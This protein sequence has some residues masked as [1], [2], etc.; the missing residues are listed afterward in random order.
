MDLAGD[1]TTDVR[2]Y[3]VLA[4]ELAQPDADRDAILA[5]HGLDE[6]AWDALDDAWQS[7]LSDAVEAMGEADD[8]PPLVQ[9]HAEAFAKAQAE[10]VSVGAPLAFER[11]IEIT[12]D[13]QRGKDVEHAMKRNGTTLHDYLRAQQ[14]WLKQM[15]D[16][17]ALQQRFHKAMDRRR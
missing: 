7:R 13:I 5:R 8:V 2:A 10:R 1:L 14:H 12:L 4:V 17:G 15:M 6:E 9:Q 16:D 3:A 11:F